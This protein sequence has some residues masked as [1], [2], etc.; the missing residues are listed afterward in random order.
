MCL[1][2]RIAREEA[3]MEMEGMTIT[4]VALGS[5]WRQ[6]GHPRKRRPLESVILDQ[7][8]SEGVLED[9]EDFISSPEWY[10]NR[11]MCVQFEL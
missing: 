4:Y 8:V 5:E 1:I 10:M 6:F 7:R 2:D 11:G 3:L 9:V